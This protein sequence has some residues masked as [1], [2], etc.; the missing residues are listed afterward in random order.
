MPG[1]REELLLEKSFG[2]ELSKLLECKECLGS[3]RLDKAKVKRDNTFQKCSQFPRVRP[4][5]GAK[6]ESFGDLE[7]I[8]S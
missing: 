3:R 1:G 4:A 2:S 7:K 5:G 8:L 6:V